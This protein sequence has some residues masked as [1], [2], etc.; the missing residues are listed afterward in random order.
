MVAHGFL[1]E[2]GTKPGEVPFWFPTEFAGFM[3]WNVARAV[4]SGLRFRP[5]AETARDTWA[6]LQHA[7]PP[8]QRLF[9]V[10]V[11]NDFTPERERALLESWAKRA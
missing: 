4:E 5:L 11:R 1:Q 9:G 10:D 7:P 8:A 3:R 2:Q 6:W